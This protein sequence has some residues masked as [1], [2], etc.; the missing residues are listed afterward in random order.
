MRGSHALQSRIIPTIRSV[1]G[2]LGA[3][4]RRRAVGNDVRR[5]GSGRYHAH[6]NVQMRLLA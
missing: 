5:E 2:E 6:G 1:A 4:K 3:N